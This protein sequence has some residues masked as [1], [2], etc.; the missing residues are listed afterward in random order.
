MYKA[1]IAAILL[2]GWTT[3]GLAQTSAE[4]ASYKRAVVAMKEGDWD[5]ARAE[6]RHAGPVGRD[7]IEW[8]RFRASEGDFG[9]VRKFLV[10]RA[11]WP[12]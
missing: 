2:S 6:A 12:G 3:V 10:R 7:I 8:R 1:L 11:D 4:I 9:S 5:R